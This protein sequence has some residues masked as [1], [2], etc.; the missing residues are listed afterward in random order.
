M[1]DKFFKVCVL[2][3]YAGIGFFLMGA[4]D[5][6]R[7][8]KDNWS[9]CSGWELEQQKDDACFD[10]LKSR[11]NHKHQDIS[12]FENRGKTLINAVNIID[13]IGV[14]KSENALVALN[15]AII[16]SVQIFGCL[17]AG[18]GYLFS[19]LRNNPNKTPKMAAFVGF[20]VFTAIGGVIGNF[21]SSYFAKTATRIARYQTRNNELKD[22]RN[23]VTYTDEQIN[24][25]KKKLSS[26]G[27][28]NDVTDDMSIKESMNPVKVYKKSFE[29]IKVLKNDYERY[30]KWHEKYRQDELNTDK[31]I[32]QIKL[33][34]EQKSQAEKDK[35]FILKI[36]RKLEISSNNYEVNVAFAIRALVALLS[37]LS[38]CG[39]F[40]LCWG[41]GKL[42]SGTKSQILSKTLNVL[43]KLSI[44]AGI[45]GMF[46]TAGPLLK[47][48]KESANLGRFKEREMMLKD[49][50]NFYPHTDT[51]IA[52][53]RKSYR[54]RHSQKPI[55]KKMA[56][57]FKAMGKIKNDYKDYTDYKNNRKTEELKLNEIL[58]TM[59]I[60][61]EQ[62]V[63]AKNLQHQT[64]MAFEKIDDKSEC[65]VDDANAAVSSICSLVNS[66]INC[67]SK[68]LT[69]TLFGKEIKKL[70][71]N[72]SMPGFFEGLKLARKLSLGKIAMIFIVPYVI[73]RGIMVLAALWGAEVKKKACKIG[74]MSAMKELNKP[75]KFMKTPKEEILFSDFNSN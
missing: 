50:R 70:T 74:I 12:K 7:L 55:L 18:L 63:D 53:I 30:K 25:A 27:E 15:S 2:V 72:K 49:K 48:A 65:L 42:S 67:I 34:T 29:S 59:P 10:E 6:L 20:S 38:V 5:N 71:Q 40:T 60:S 35:N 11:I 13:Q 47:I 3:H 4:I 28:V 44:P 56:E 64:F 17:G 39:G 41:F 1:T 26:V 57:Y 52:K 45:A 75:E 62:L 31:E 69:L 51:E 21:I 14:N 9:V 58:K 33:S 37:T 54:K 16:T 19:K 43:S 32:E 46:L 24:T 8:V 68:I 73:A 66:T 22:V 23:F 36:I 61:D